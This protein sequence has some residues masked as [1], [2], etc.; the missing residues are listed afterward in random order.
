MYVGKDTMDFVAIGLLFQ[1]FSCVTVL[2]LPESPVYLLKRQRYSELREAFK[3]IA[4][5][6]GIKELPKKCE[7]I[8]KDNPSP[9]KQ[10]QPDTNDKNATKSPTNTKKE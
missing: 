3:L 1:I 4:S 7:L 6:N 2:Y 5:W 9:E 8:L 10:K